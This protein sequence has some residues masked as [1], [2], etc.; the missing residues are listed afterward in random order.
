M[1]ICIGGVLLSLLTFGVVQAQ[2]GSVEIP[3]E[4]TT[5]GKISTPP[6]TLPPLDSVDIGTLPMGCNQLELYVLAGQSNMKGRG[7]MPQEPNRDPRIMMMHMKD[8]AWYMAR[9][10]LHLTGDAKTFAGHDNAGVGPGMSFA[11][12]LISQ[13]SKLG[14]GLIPCA[15][16]GSR[17]QLWQKG[18]KL[19]EEAIRRTK[20]AIY[21]SSKH[22]A[23]VRG[24]L[25]LQGEANANAQDLEQHAQRLSTVIRN[26]RSDLQEANLPFIV[27]T[28]GEMGAGEKLGP[29]QEMNAILLDL[30]HRVP[31]TACVD[32]RDLK[33][34]IGDE[35][36][37]DTAAQDEIGRRFAQKLSDLKR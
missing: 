28:I 15:V 25:W 22:G 17:I 5:G 1:R 30:S 23:R 7:V 32:A 21:L 2:E 37:F 8:D 24:V 26:F 19:Y 14:V 13:N 3:K 6:P 12:T 10:P 4:R 9:H 35:V 16:G 33:T 18:A 31:F 11:E 36:H 20:L 34:H 27:C 29:K